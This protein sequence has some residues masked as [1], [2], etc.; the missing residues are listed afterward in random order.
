MEHATKAPSHQH[1]EG[2]V[3]QHR[4]APTTAATLIDNRPGTIAQRE[5][6]VAVST[7]TR[8][9]ALQGSPV[10][11]F[12]PRVIAQRRR[13]ERM[14]GN[15]VGQSEHSV[16]VAQLLMS[17][18][19]FN[20]KMKITDEDDIH[21]RYIA[22]R[23]YVYH[24]TVK[25]KY[26]ERLRCLRWL[27]HDIYTW[28]DR[29]K[30]KVP[31]G[32]PR[33]AVMNDLLNE[34]ETEHQGIIRDIQFTEDENV[35]I[36]VEGLDEKTVLKVKEVWEGILTGKSNIKL[37]TGGRFGDKMLAR[38][39]KLLQTSIGQQLLSELGKPQNDPSRQIRIVPNLPQDIDE[40]KKGSFAKPIEEKRLARSLSESI[41]GAP[42]VRDQHGLVETED[43]SG[44]PDDYPVV[45]G[46]KQVND[47]IMKG[48]TKG[49]T[50][51]GTRYRFGGGQGSHVRIQDEKGSNVDKD[52]NKIATPGFVT[53]GHEL[54]H[55]L[56][57]L[58]GGSLG[59]PTLYSEHAKEFGL[60]PSL[61]GL[62]KA[63]WSDL[64]EFVNINEVENQIRQETGMS[65]RSFH[66]VKVTEILNKR[67]MT[68]MLNQIL[69]KVPH[70]YQT[71]VQ[72]P[73]ETVSEQLLYR[74]DWDFGVPEVVEKTR[75]ALLR[76]Q[77][78]MLTLIE[79]AKIFDDLQARYYKI[80]NDQSGRQFEQKLSAHQD[81]LRAVK[82]ADDI[83]RKRFFE[84]KEAMDQMRQAVEFLEKS[85]GVIAKAIV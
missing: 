68:L 67:T 29:N 77:E 15:A 58:R 19:D 35:P 47:A 55:A 45:E 24:D 53:L 12:S 22:V 52:L 25:D 76:W 4:A 75:S 72:G 37:S 30:S 49:V 2:P 36:D 43:T 39:A 34:S 79:E 83:A 7:G 11:A 64:E 44:S 54:G 13:L 56:R 74:E 48:T 69:D 50:W 80:F 16:P 71:Y 81:I 14:F 1:R 3:R 61:E 5:L 33:I 57:I 20:T 84:S 26:Q 46:R 38:I 28:L 82:I 59:T 51:G 70:E 60:D 62:D 6:A 73:I 9:S 63:V 78:H 23:L 18:G 27:D 42:V 31:E 41:F 40:G 21:L 65:L 10:L 32:N 17:D 8:V 85:S 66:A